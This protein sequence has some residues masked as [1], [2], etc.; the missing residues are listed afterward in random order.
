[1]KLPESSE[2]LEWTTN[3]DVSGSAFVWMHKQRGFCAA[4]QKVPAG[5]GWGLWGMTAK[6]SPIPEGK[7]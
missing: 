5:A 7:R 1:M 6:A 4:G 3:R 2:V